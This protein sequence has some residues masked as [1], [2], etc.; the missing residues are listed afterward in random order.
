MK[1]FILLFFALCTIAVPVF[2]R[3]FNTSNADYKFPVTGKATGGISK[4]QD[5]ILVNINKGVLLRESNWTAA[6]A[7]RHVVGI[8]AVLG[9]ASNG[10]WQMIAKSELVSLDRILNPKETISL[11]GLKFE[12]P[13]EGLAPA[14]LDKSWLA[15]EIVVES[16]NKETQQYGP[17]ASSGQTYF[18]SDKTLRGNP[19]GW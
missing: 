8:R 15:F 18:H 5:K 4:G 11:D 17:G 14:Q 9:E 12:I 10:S 2:A 19:S 7:D 3:P 13:T 6:G 16:R 1:R